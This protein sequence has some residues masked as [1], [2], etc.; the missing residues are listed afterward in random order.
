MYWNFEVL[1]RI[2]VVDDLKIVLYYFD[3][4]MIGMLIWIWE[5]KVDN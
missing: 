3:M 4:N 1:I 2:D 5:V